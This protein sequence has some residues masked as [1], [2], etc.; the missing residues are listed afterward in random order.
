MATFQYPITAFH[1]SVSFL[2]E[3]GESDFD[4]G[5]QSVGGLDVQI[6]TETIKEGGENRFEHVLPVRS[7]YSDLVL[8]KG[9]TRPDNSKLITWCKDT[10]EKLIFTPKN[11]LITLLNE[12]HQ[13]LLSWRVAHAWPKSWKMQELNAEKGE[14]LIQTLELN[15][16]YFSFTAE[17]Q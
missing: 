17:K 9:L 14:I 1:F 15:Y 4:V 16:N 3:A 12:E 6:E 10:F 11:L 7:K 2:N 5:F 13:P 8:K